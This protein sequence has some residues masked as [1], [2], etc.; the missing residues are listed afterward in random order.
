MCSYPCLLKLGLLANLS[1]GGGGCGGTWDALTKC[2]LN[3]QMNERSALFKL[4][5][6]IILKKKLHLLIYLPIC[7]NFP[8]E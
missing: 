2:L 5:Y 6:F 4:I 7:K 8:T 3:K 1:L